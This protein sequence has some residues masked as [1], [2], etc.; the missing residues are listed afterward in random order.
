MLCSFEISP[1]KE[2]AYIFIFNILAENFI[3]FGIVTLSFLPQLLPDPPT[4]DPFQAPPPFFFK[5]KVYYLAVGKFSGYR[6]NAARFSYISHD[7]LL[8]QVL[9]KFLFPSRISWLLFS[10]L[11]S[12]KLLLAQPSKLGLWY[13][14]AHSSGGT[15]FMVRGSQQSGRTWQ[16]WWDRHTEDTGK[17][18]WAGQ[19][20]KPVAQWHTSSRLYRASK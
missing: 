15:E 3:S 4:P 2:S 18:K 9:R 12:P 17:R 7:L 10:A 19:D 8:A 1:A 5:K 14:K 20:Y 11:L 16:Q 6:Q 13:S